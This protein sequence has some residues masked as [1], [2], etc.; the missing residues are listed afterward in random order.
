MPEG[1]QLV[2]NRRKAFRSLSDLLYFQADLTGQALGKWERPAWARRADGAL[3]GYDFVL[4]QF[5][6][7]KIFF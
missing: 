5:F 3:S 6:I 2:S 7:L 4:S 1:Q